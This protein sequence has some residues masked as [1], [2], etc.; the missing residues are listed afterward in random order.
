MHQL[1]VEKKP[2]F[3]KVVSFLEK[4]LASVRTG[5][6]STAL[7]E[8]LKVEAYGSA[9]ELKNMA[10]ISIPDAQ[11][12]QIEPWDAGVVGEIEKAIM[13]SG[14]GIT[15]S[16][17]GK[18]I[19]LAIPPLTEETRKNLVKVIG[20]KVEEAR[21]S[22][23]NVRDEVKKDIEALEK[24]KEVSE[25]ERYQMQEQL[26]TLTGEYNEKIAGLGSAKEEEV[27]KV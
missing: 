16:T 4:D 23:R 25:D 15:P 13:E 1:L 19:R 26:D 12:V 17:A 21:I 5:R 2:A 20:K 8:S 9:Q 3:E 10:A 14:I 22:V 7:V 11:T 24:A 27:M 6:A 18:T